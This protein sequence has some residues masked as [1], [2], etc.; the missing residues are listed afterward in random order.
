MHGDIKN[1][2]IKLVQKYIVKDLYL[3]RRNILLD[4]H[5]TAKLSDFGITQEI[6]R[7]TEGRCV[8]TAAIVAKSFGYVHI[9]P[10]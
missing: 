7:L 5:L 10:P 8:I 4:H 2:S 1:A 3:C 6:P 9:Q